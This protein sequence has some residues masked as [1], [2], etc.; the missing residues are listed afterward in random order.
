MNSLRDKYKYIL[1][2]EFQD[3]S[4]INLEILKLLENNNLYVIGDVD[5]SVYSFINA[6]VGN[7]INFID[8]F[9]N[10]EVISLPHNFRSTQKII[11]ICNDLL[12]KYR[13]PD[14]PL[15]RFE[16]QISGRGIDG[17]DVKVVVYNDEFIEARDIV[18]D[19]KRRK[20]ADP[21]LEYKD[22]CIMSRTNNGLLAFENELS[23]SEVPVTLS[24]GGS[25]Y[26]RKEIDDLLSYAQLYVG[27]NDDAFRKVANRPNRYLA[28]S[29]LRDLEEYAFNKNLSLEQAVE[30]GFDAGRYKTNLYRFLGTIEEI[31]E[32]KQ[33]NAEKILREIYYVTNYKY[34]IQDKAMTNSEVIIKE[35]AINRLFE[36]AKKFSSIQNFLNYVAVVK[37]NAKDEKDGVIL[38]TA[39]SAKGLEWDVCYVVG[40]TDNNYPHAML[41]SEDKD[42]E[43]RLLFM[44][45]GRA[46]NHLQISLPVFEMG[47][48]KT[49]EPSRFIEPLLKDDLNEAWS[50]VI[51][52]KE[53]AEFYY[54][55]KE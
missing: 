37:S 51:S 1:V 9:E 4:V 44:A 8:D 43:L 17:D 38:S 2:D 10:V 42:E 50:E 39:H 46:K 54:E 13:D 23:I 25:F 52:G 20:E 28:N 31:R 36:S 15:N 47:A 27:E 48:T 12:K 32:I 6:E 33:K 22:F 26:D 40:V 14:H 29:M 19:I 34:F 5:Q 49:Y 16:K 11:D 41:L 30:K 55:H 35:D 45:L 3:T 18:E 7:I 24:S 53:K 21:S